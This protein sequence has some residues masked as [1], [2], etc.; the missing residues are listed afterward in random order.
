MTKHKP[1]LEE[2]TFLP[3]GLDKFVLPLSTI[4]GPLAEAIYPHYLR[5]KKERFNNNHHFQLQLNKDGELVYSTLQDVALVDEIIRDYGGR[6]LLPED[7]HNDMTVPDMIKDKNYVDRFALVLRGPSSPLHDKRAKYIAETLEEVVEVNKLRK[8][9]ALVTGLRVVPAT[10]GYGFVFQ[11]NADFKAVYSDKFTTEYHDKRFNGFDKDGVPTDFAEDG[12]FR[13]YNGENS[14][15]VSRFVL[16]RDWYS[17]SFWLRFDFSY[18]G[19]RV[20]VTASE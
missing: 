11:P 18:A 17:D 10:E 20:V 1:K 6:V 16:Y 2:F 8:T 15:R 19:G 7:F 4:S 5:L 12:V 9:P 3:K 14:P 13:N